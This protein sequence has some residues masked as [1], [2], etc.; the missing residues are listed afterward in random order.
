MNPYRSVI[1]AALVLPPFTTHA[2]MEDDPLL[3]KGII[4]QLELRDTDEGTAL[5]WE[6]EAWLGRDLD[7]L[8]LKTEGE[9]IHGETEEAELQLLYSRAIAPYWDLQLG[10]RHDIKPEPD[11][12]WLAVGVKGVAPYGFEVDAALFVGE[13]GRTAAR[14]G[15]EYELLFTQQWVLTPELELNLH[16]EDDPIHGIGSGLSDM[17]LGLRL[18]YEVNRHVAPYVGIHWSKKFGG[19]ADYARADGGDDEEAHFVA[20]IRAWF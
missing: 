2:G 20:G 6:V 10:W 3:F 19:T 13:S 16:S 5:A 11:R 7:K 14:L 12:D 1:L 8:W 18:R 15:A 17:S 4:D 9:R